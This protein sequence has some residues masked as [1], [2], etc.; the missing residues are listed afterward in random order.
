MIAG[1]DR[2]YACALAWL[3]PAQADG[4]SEPALRSALAAALARHNAAAG[5]AARIERLVLLGDPADLDAGEITDKGYVNQREVLRRRS[6]L[7]N[8]AY[9][10]PPP[11]EVI[12]ADA[13]RQSTTES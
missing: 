4:L 10:D 11:P 8:L 1:E 2:S 12:V 7:V 9:T 5:S 3:N 6:A 13:E